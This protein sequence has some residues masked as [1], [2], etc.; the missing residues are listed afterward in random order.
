MP[1]SE[2]VVNGIIQVRRDTTDAWSSASPL[3][4]GELGWDKEKKVLVVGD[5][6]TAFAGLTPVGTDETLKAQ[7]SGLETSKADAEQV[8][9]KTEADEKFVAQILTGDT[10]KATIFNEADGGGAKFEQTGGLTSFVGVH[11]G[12]TGG[13]KVAAQIYALRESGGKK[14]GTR[15]NVFEDKITYLSKEENPQNETQFDDAEHELAVKKDITGIQ[16]I[17]SQKVDESGLEDKI[18]EALNQKFTESVAFQFKGSVTDAAQLTEKQ[19]EAKAGDVWQV[20]G[21]D[22]QLYVWDGDSWGTFGRPGEMDISSK[23]DR[24][25][26]GTN[27]KALVFNEKDGGG[28]KFEHTDGLHSF[29]GVNDGGKS[30]LAAQIYAL[31]N[32]EG[33]WKGSRLNVYQKGIFYIPQSAGEKAKD[34]QD[35][36]LVVKADLKSFN[37]FEG[38]TVVLDGGSAAPAES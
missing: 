36:E 8:Y 11:D 9:T 4:E 27:G 29:V 13:F 2:I 23:V 1:D 26:T 24:E 25:I 6:S 34:D 15:L 33:Q 19:G 16:A 21:E 30:G 38:K 7:V 17:L 10:G 5:G 20:T 37:P 22:Q 32:A 14:I 12:S 28:A 18:A 3:R 31:E 35:Y